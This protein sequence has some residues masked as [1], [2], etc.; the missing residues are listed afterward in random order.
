MRI[1]SYYTIEVFDF[2]ESIRE[3]QLNE[4][5]ELN[6]ADLLNLISCMKTDFLF[7]LFSNFRGS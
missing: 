6:F 7:W 1:Y 4:L 5:R 2:V 3:C